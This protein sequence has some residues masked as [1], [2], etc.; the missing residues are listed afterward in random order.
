M[1][2]TLRIAFIVA[3]AVALLLGVATG[4]TP[5]ANAANGDDTFAGVKN[6][7]LFISDGAGPEHF[8]L[9]RELNGG[10]LYRDF[11]AWGGEGTLDTTSLDGVTDSAA[12]ATA[13]ATGYETH[14]GWLS[15]V[16][17]DAEDATSVKTV[18]ERAMST[19]KWAGLITD[20]GINDATPAAFAAHVT[21]RYSADIPVQMR[22]HHIQMLFGSQGWPKARPLLNLSGVT[23]IKSSKDLAPYFSEVKPWVVPM[24]GLI[25]GA[26]M[27]FDLD[28]E[29]EGVEGVQPTLPEM[30]DAALQDLSQPSNGNGFFLMVEGGAIDWGGHARDPAWVGTDVI[31]FDQ[32][33]E[34]AHDW[35]KARSDTLIVVTSDHETGG[36]AVDGT[37]DYTAIARQKATT[38]YTWSLIKR[39][40]ITIEEALKSYMGVVNPTQKEIGLV[41]KW[42]EMGISDVL[43]ARDNVTWGWSGKDD[44]EHTA[45][46]VPVLAWGPGASVF[47]V[48]QIDNEYVGTELMQAVSN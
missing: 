5:Q 39:G 7:I 28:R 32:A 42:H 22:D 29:E 20:V 27:T 9:G 47:N 8:E 12:A 40:K 24:Y 45:T 33:V 15:M 44:G 4:A 13:L 2:K 46:P 41:T 19:G 18:L 38:D 6:V 48:T 21:D 34:V 30:T 43:A 1:A 35:A 11:I 14:N 16:G 10:W 3:L 36:L 31:E 26:A 23:Y 17:P 25:G 37:T